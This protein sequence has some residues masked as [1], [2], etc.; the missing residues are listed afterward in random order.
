MHARAERVVWMVDDDL[1]FRDL[2]SEVALDA[3]IAVVNMSTADLEERRK[4]N[5]PDGAMLDGVVLTGLDAERY[6]EGI[7]RIVIC[8]GREYLEIAERWTAHPHVRVL[9][10][11]MELEAFEDAIRWLAGADDGSSWPTPRPSPT[12]R[13]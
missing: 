7:P 13:G 10:K 11:P 3:D 4:V 5:L 1:S 8:T 12:E 9:L 6:L 2:S